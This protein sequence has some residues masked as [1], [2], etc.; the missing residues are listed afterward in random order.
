MPNSEF[1]Q[2][3]NTETNAPQPKNKQIAV[4]QV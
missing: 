2:T 4:V 3:T 1:G